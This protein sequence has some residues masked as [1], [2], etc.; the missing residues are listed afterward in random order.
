MQGNLWGIVFLEYMTLLPCLGLGSAVPVQITYSAQ[1]SLLSPDNGTPQTSTIWVLS[2]P[3][4]GNLQVD[5]LTLN[6]QS[7]NFPTHS[8][9]V[10][11]DIFQSTW[12]LLLDSSLPTFRKEKMWPINSCYPG[13]YCSVCH[14]SVSWFLESKTH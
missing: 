6:C 14:L 2:L 4:H 11:V 10:I 5:L 12:R 9:Q 3:S 1:L 8:Q 7:L 13:T